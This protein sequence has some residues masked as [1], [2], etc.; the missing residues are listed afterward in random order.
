MENL[1]YV[2]ALVVLDGP[3]KTPQ[4]GSDLFWVEQREEAVEE[5][6]Q[7]HWHSMEALEV[8]RCFENLNL[9]AVKESKSNEFTCRMRLAT[10]MTMP[11][12]TRSRGMPG[13]NRPTPPFIASTT[14]RGQG[15][16]TLG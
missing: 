4:H 13:P 14:A 1:E 2:S 7:L 11:G 6:F 9:D 5:H 3:P 10:S 16:S 8:K 15:V 12:E